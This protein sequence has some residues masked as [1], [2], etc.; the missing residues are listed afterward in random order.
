M[1]MPNYIIFITLKRVFVCLTYELWLLQFSSQFSPG[2]YETI[3]ILFLV[4]SLDSDDYD[5][6]MCPVRL[7]H[8]FKFTLIWLVI[9]CLQFLSDTFVALGKTVILILIPVEVNPGQIRILPNQVFSYVLIQNFEYMSCYLLGIIGFIQRHNVT[10]TSAKW[11]EK[12]MKTFL[13]SKVTPSKIEVGPKK[14]FMISWRIMVYFC[15][16][17]S[18]QIRLYGQTSKGSIW[19]IHQIFVGSFHL[20]TDIP[21]IICVLYG[22]AKRYKSLENGAPPW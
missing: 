15:V 7:K 14:P 10:E 6:L 17:T 16:Y 3:T 11:S 21:Y 4:R 20:L 9:E 13:C 18:L 1:K 19:N 22:T 2:Q 5:F 12:K 8:F